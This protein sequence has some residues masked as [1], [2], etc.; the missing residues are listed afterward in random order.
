MRAGRVRGT[1][2]GEHNHGV[3]VEVC[4]HA[5][6]TTYLRP[7]SQE[8]FDG[9]EGLFAAEVKSGEPFFLRLSKYLTSL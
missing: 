1:E 8:V 5:S 9:H 7:S 3:S 4:G 2:R 6:R